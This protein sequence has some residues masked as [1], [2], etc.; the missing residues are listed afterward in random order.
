VFAI[1]LAILVAFSKADLADKDE[2]KKISRVKIKKVESSPIII[3]S[4]TRFGITELLDKLWL[5]IES[6]EK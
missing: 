1:S 5:A 2:L 6:A 4:A 3:S